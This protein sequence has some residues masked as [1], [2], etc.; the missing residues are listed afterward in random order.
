MKFQ[1]TL[2]DLCPPIDHLTFNT[3]N[4]I[5]TRVFYVVVKLRNYSVCYN[6]MRNVNL[7]INLLDDTHIKYVLMS[8]IRQFYLTALTHGTKEKRSKPDE[9]DEIK[10][11]ANCFRLS[12]ISL[13]FQLQKVEYKL[14]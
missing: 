14:D 2:A 11:N 3:T 10:Q 7:Y 12:P 8:A 4:K 13:S 6:E 9:S 1:P 5:Y